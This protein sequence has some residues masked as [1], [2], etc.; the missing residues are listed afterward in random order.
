MKFLIPAL[1]VLM[2]ACGQPLPKPDEARATG[3]V[4]AAVAAGAVAVDPPTGGGSH[5]KVSGPSSGQILTIP[6]NRP[7]KPVYI[8][9]L[10]RM[11]DEGQVDD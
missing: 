7:I 10:V 6:F 3:E 9:A 1:A 5:Y 11:I 8:R 4:G 2:V